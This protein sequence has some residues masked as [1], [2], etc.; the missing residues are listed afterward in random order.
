MGSGE[1][2]INYD[3]VT[4][5][6]LPDN[7]AGTFAQNRATVHLHGGKSPWISDG[8]PHQWTVPAGEVTDYAKGVS[9]SYVPDM[10]FNASGNTITACAG[11]NTCGVAGATN[12]PGPGA[13]TFYYPNQQSGRFLFYHDHAWGITRLNVYAGEAAGYLIQDNVELA[14][15]NGGTVNGRVFTAGTI[16]PSA[17]IPLVIQDK[18]YVDAATILGPTG[19]DPTWNWGTGPTDANGNITAAATG[20]LWINHVYMSAEN[21]YNPDGG[22]SSFG[23]WF[24]GPWFYPPTPLCGSSPDA[25]PPYCITQGPVPNYHYINDP[26]CYPNH[27]SACT[28]PPEQPGTPDVSWGAESFMDTMLVNGTV[29]PTV[30][31]NPQAYRFRILSAGNDRFLNLQ[32]YL[33]DDTYAPTDPGFG[34]EVKM[35]PSAQRASCSATVTTNC[36]C[37]ATDAPAGCFPDTWPA[38]GREGGVPDPAMRGPAW[39]QIGTE[40]GFLPGP[41][42]RPNIPVTWNYDPT[43]FDIGNVNNGALILAPAERADVI[44]DFTPFAGKTLILYNDAP[45]AFPALGTAIRLLHRRPGP[46]GHRRCRR[47]I[48]GLRSERPDGHAGQ[49]GGKRRHRAPRLLQPGDLDRAGARVPVGPRGQRGDDLRDDWSLRTGAGPDHRGA[50]GLR[51]RLQQDVPHGRSELGHLEDQ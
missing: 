10:W 37:T 6:L 8:T 36:V 26:N 1:Y 9:V 46:H 51:C 20:D 34:K 16:P 2:L 14:M 7:V 40:G 33:A 39:V 30:T 47:D 3:P 44:V 25:V 42:V 50:D 32:W 22:M 41:V 35:V 15:M 19:T 5:A 11:N 17:M 27:T 4:K 13:L 31:V 38:D 48:A 18:T 21:P 28:Q 23:R 49:G 45:T 43:T 12:N 29:Y 24:Y